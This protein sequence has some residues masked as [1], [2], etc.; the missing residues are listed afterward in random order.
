MIKYILNNFNT[1][2]KI[3]ENIRNDDK[4]FLK[5]K[6]EEKTD[7]TKIDLEHILPRKPQKWNLTVEEVKGYVNM[8]G[9]FTILSSTLNSSAQHFTITEK[10]KHYKNSSLEINKILVNEI[11]S[12]DSVWNQKSIIERQN[13]FSN[14]ALR[15]WR[16]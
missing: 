6:I 7:F 12:N 3:P 2:F 15:L 9:N 10:I 11:E 13:N 14:L 1:Y 16:F 5:F 4:K 8:L